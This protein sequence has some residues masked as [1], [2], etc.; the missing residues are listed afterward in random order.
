MFL[1]E[2]EPYASDA[3]GWFWTQYK[4]PI[5]LNKLAD[6][7]RFT[8]ITEVING[9]HNGIQERKRFLENAKKSFGI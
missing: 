2:Q 1:V 9:G 7:D 8:R 3:S 4:K 6:Q 5:N